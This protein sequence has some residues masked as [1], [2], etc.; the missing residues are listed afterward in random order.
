[1]ALLTMTLLGCSPLDGPSSEGTSSES[2]E[3]GAVP[4]A[5]VDT[6]QPGG[7][8]YERA[9]RLDM[10]NPD[11][12]PI[13]GPKGD[14]AF[15]PPIRYGY[16]ELSESM[17]PVL[18][19]EDFADRSENY[20]AV[21]FID[22]VPGLTLEVSSD[23][24]FVAYGNYFDDVVDDLAR[25][26]PSRLLL[27]DG[28]FDEVYTASADLTSVQALNEVARALIGAGDVPVT[29]LRELKAAQAAALPPVD[30]DEVG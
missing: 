17:S 7:A 3:G 29:R 21:E 11:G 12:S 6:L 15:G 30:P 8:A 23:G 10:L 2:T 9:A 13:P 5:V 22:G 18:T 24:E 26:D 27:T 19:N 28:R 20:I 4:D 1:M 25:L 16:L 14:V